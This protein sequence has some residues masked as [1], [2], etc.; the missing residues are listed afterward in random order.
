VNHVVGTD[1]RE[2]L[3]AAKRIVVK[4]GSRS[5]AARPGLTLSLAQQIK[6]LRDEGRVVV[7]VSSGAVALGM[8]RL[9]F[10]SRP[11]EVGQLQAAAS[12]G[13][14]EL[15]RRYDEAFR[16]L[17][18][19]AAQVLLTHGDLSNRK[20]V[21]NARNALAAL[22]EAGAVPIINENDAVATDELRFSDNDQL[23]AMVTPL[24]DA[25]AL[26]LL[27]DVDGVLD[28]N[29][30]RISILDKITDFT[31]RGQR[32]SVGRGGMASKLDA[33]HKARH[34]GAA[35]VIAS[36][37]TENVLLKILAGEDIG[38]GLP[39][40]G[41]TLRARQHWIAYALRPRGTIIVDNGASVAL[42]DGN[43][44]LLPIGVIGLRGEFRRGDSVK[45]ETTEGQEIA[46]GLSRMSALEIAR[47]A[48]KKGSE[49]QNALGGDAEP[50]VIHRDDLVLLS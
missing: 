33:A 14:S 2:A 49:L 39:Q 28:E 13:Q 5:L 10:A 50:V 40:V 36:A 43:K 19:V 24:V 47:A 27:T 1:V 31:D 12:A 46:R 34:S 8:E 15:M 22:I 45:V 4:V 25:D 44:S 17:G 3:R 41:S 48:G 6:A 18:L 29:G 35:V 7:L 23:S 9:G 26:T 37:L 21:N 30:N 42:K 32:G 38:T 20:R 16:G 11:T